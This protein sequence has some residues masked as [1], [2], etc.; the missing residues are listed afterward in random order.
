MKKNKF[1]KSAVILMIGGLFTKLLGMIIRI[2]TSRI[3]GKTGIGIYSLISPTFMLFIA[4]SQLGFPVAISKLVAEQKRNNKKLILGLIPISLIIN[5]LLMGLLFFISPILSKYLLHEQRCTYALICI[6]F[7]LPF[8]SI[9]SI[10][11]GYFF[12]KERMFIH[13]FSNLM[14][15]V[16]RIILILIFLPMFLNIS[17]ESAI[18][19]LVFSNIASELTSIIIFLIFLPKNQS[20]EKKDF[21]LDSKNRKDVFSIGIPLTSSRLIGNIGA[22]LEPVIITSVLIKVGY[23]SSFIVEEYG[24]L[25]GFVMPVLLLPSFFTMAISQAMVP[26]ISKSYVDG[27][28]EYV[29]KKIKQ[30]I[31]LSLS[32]GIPITIFL[33]INPSFLLEFLYQ[34]NEGSVYLQ[35]LAPIFLLQYIQSPMSSSLQAIG[36][37]I[38]SMKATLL[39]T[40]TRILCLLIFSFFKIGLWPLVIAISASIFLTSLYEAKALKKILL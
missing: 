20:L 2:L 13:V 36:K 19:F 6:G 25:N 7:V 5:L 3:L 17:L 28:K 15:D 27:K 31:I 33:F 21:I 30:G 29:L 32:V 8:I 4:L 38:I 35:V 11:R 37:A 40:T 9:S 39:G 10:L 22:F 16:V 34:T 18:A 24:V 12:G 26:A 1:I 14:E 23:E